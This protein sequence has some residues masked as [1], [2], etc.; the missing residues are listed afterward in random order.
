MARS[1][2]SKDMYRQMEEMMKKIDKL[3][4]EVNHLKLDLKFEKEENKRKDQKI[5]NRRQNGL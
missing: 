4:A 2:Y 1:N 5:N 3:L